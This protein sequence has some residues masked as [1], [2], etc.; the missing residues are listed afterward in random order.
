MPKT[1]LLALRSGLFYLGYYLVTIL[2]SVGFILVF[3]L[4]RER[5]RY[6]MATWWCSFILVWLRICCGVRYRVLGKE[7]LP[8]EPGVILANHQ[9]SW[10]TILIYKLVFPVAPILKRELLNIPFWGWAIRLQRPIAIDRS[11]PREAGKSLLVQGVDRIR[12]GYSIMIF[13]EGT[14]SGPGMTKRFS[15]GGARLAIAAGAPIVPIAHNAGSCWPPHRFIKTPG[16]ITV[17]I[18]APLSTVGK[19]DN[20]LT[21]TVAAWV[22]EQLSGMKPVS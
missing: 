14:R 4:V 1:I 16:L 17:S 13:P 2:M 15:R 9:S 7:H 19:D 12:R 5:T 3:P 20:L 22:E 21:E 10:E 18:G 6:V 11:K 8:A